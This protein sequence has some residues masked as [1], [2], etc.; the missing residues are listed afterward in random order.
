MTD[1]EI[2]LVRLTMDAIRVINQ[3]ALE[4]DDWRIAQAGNTIAERLNA[5]VVK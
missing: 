4:Q 1:K 5:L 3:I 2:E